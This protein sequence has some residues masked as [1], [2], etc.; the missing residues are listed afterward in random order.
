MPFFTTS[1]FYILVG[2]VTLGFVIALIWTNIHKKAISNFICYL[3]QNQI[4]DE[5]KAIKLSDLKIKGLSAYIIE[6]SLTKGYGISKY[7]GVIK[8]KRSRDNLEAM[9]EE[10]ECDRYY[11]TC[12]DTMMLIKKYSFTPISIKL[13]I[14]LVIAIVV[15]AILST[16]ALKAIIANSNST[17]FD[18]GKDKQNSEQYSEEDDIT[19]DASTKPQSDVGEDD[20]NVPKS[21]LP[22]IPI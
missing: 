19:N 1:T 3:C 13:L 20:K 7:V 9:L 21:S 18:S 4:F 22:R 5:G 16:F 6:R 14:L 15:T 17:N 12:N 11:L 10:K 2:A 8:G